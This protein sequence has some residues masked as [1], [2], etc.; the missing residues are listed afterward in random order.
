METYLNF[1]EF[2]LNYYLI[3]KFFINDETDFD[4]LFKKLK[5]FKEED[6]LS[7]KDVVNLESKISRIIKNMDDIVEFKFLFYEALNNAFDILAYVESVIPSWLTELYTYQKEIIND[8]FFDINNLK[9][10]FGESINE[11]DIIQ[12]FNKKDKY[13]VSNDNWYWKFLRDI[14]SS[15]SKKLYLDLVCD[16]LTEKNIN[17]NLLISRVMNIARE[18]FRNKFPNSYVLVK[19]IMLISLFN[20]LHILKGDNV[21][22]NKNLNLDEMLDSPSKKSSFLVG[23]L[24]KKLMNIQYMELESS[25]FYNKLY[26]LEI[27]EKKLRNIYRKAY[28]KLRQYGRGYGK[29]EEKISENLA[30]C[31]NKWNLNKDETSY[32]FLLGMTLYKLYDN[33]KK[34]GEL[35]E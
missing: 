17:Y 10:I 11:T 14:F 28:D 22:E 20:K 21:M 4:M 27:D 7:S 15:F 25:P 19:S 33:E 13:P 12:I 31:V 5:R 18:N 1:K 35:N 9:L 26:G 32:F 30:M 2:G 23:V 29:L 8:V 34:E 3:P 24:V 16:V 6:N